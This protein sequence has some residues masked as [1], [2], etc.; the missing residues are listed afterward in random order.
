MVEL[1][2]KYRDMVTESWRESNDQFYEYIYTNGLKAQ[3]QISE[4]LDDADEEGSTP[5]P[6]NRLLAIAADSAD[7]V[8][9]TKKTTNVNINVDFAKQLEAAISRSR[10]IES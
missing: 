2:S 8:G 6:V 5:I 7:R 1:V 10:R 9:Y 4:A 3:R